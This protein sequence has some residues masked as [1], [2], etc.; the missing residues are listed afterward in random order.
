MA[1]HSRFDLKGQLE[2]IK[3]NPI[4]T[5]TQKKEDKKAVRTLLQRLIQDFLRPYDEQDRTTEPVMLVFLQQ[6]RSQWVPDSH[7]WELYTKGHSKGRP[8]L[9]WTINKDP[10][11]FF[12][13][14]L[15][16]AQ[17]CSL[18]PDCNIGRRGVP[19]VLVSSNSNIP[20]EECLRLFPFFVS[21]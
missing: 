17:F 6:K 16:M 20:G 9:D 21:S 4:R 1:I 11:R 12:H 7:N 2:T 14:M 3:N 5:R 19:K 13:K 18:S 8:A 15:L 10:V